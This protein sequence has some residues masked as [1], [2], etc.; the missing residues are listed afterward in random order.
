MSQQAGA[1]ASRNEPANV[2]GSHSDTGGTTD[3]S[4]KENALG[5][6][7]EGRVQNVSWGAIFAGVVTFLAIVFVFSLL[8][9]AAGLDGSGTGAAVVS[10]IGLLLAFFGAGGVAGAMS[11][12]GGLVHG[13][14]TWA[15]SLLATV[16]LLVLLT[17]GAAGAVGGILGS[18]VSGLGRRRGSLDHQSAARRRPRTHRGAEP[19]GRAGPTAG[20]GDG[21]PGRRRDADRRH[22]RV[23]RPPAR[24]RCRIRRRSPRVPLGQ[25]PAGARKSSPR[26]NR[27][28]STRL[29]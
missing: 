12:R 23:L 15:T 19:A 9:A 18:L 4:W 1:T 22:V 29:K 11:V 27:A 13:F 25:Q 7:R 6:A 16:L 8:T 17:L 26:L 2:A 28:I 20:A 14:L 21:P 3:V 5:N 24:R 10:I